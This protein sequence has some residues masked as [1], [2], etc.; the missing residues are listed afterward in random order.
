MKIQDVILLIIFIY[1]L[2]KH[3]S[4]QFILLGILCFL[5]SIPLFYFWVFFTAQRLIYFG[6]FFLLCGIISYFVQ[7]KNK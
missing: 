2:Y 1:L 5:A 4:R 3:N 6:S 7:S